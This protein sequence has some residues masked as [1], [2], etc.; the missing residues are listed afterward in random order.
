MATKKSV[1]TVPLTRRAVEQ[2]INRALTKQN[3]FAKLI[4]RRGQAGWVELGDYYIID[5]RT[6]ALLGH[7]IDIEAHA[8]KLKV[9]EDW[10]F[11]EHE[12]GGR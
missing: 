1:R 12:K 8:R 6:N 7:H 3:Q 5:L 4:K 9:L 2:R 11:L 10:E